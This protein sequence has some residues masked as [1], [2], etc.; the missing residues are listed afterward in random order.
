[1]CHLRTKFLRSFMSAASC[2]AGNHLLTTGTLS[3]LLA[4]VQLHTFASLFVITFKSPKGL[5]LFIIIT[6]NKSLSLVEFTNCFRSLHRG[7]R[8]LFKQ[9]VR[10]I[11]VILRWCSHHLLDCGIL[12][13]KIQ[14]WG[15]VET[16]YE[17]LPCCVDTKEH[18]Q[19]KFDYRCL[20]YYVV[21]I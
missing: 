9:M 12:C 13:G 16:F 20:I 19:R 14:F 11:R 5:L 1:M 2:C 17:L 18:R 7:N 6:V 8:R 4:E 3:A 10:R 15:R 21:V